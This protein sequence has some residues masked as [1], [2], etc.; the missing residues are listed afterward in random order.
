MILAIT[1][2]TLLF[3]KHVLIPVIGREAF[4]A[5]ALVSKNLHNYLGPAFVLGVVLMLIAWIRHNFPKW[6]DVQWVLKGGGLV[7]SAHPS[8]GR[9]NAGEKGWFWFIA[10]VGLVA[11]ASGIV[12]DF[13]DLV[14]SRANLQLAN[15]I[16]IA[17]TVAWVGGFFGHAYIGT[18]GSE[19]SVEGM[20]TGK[21]DVNWAKQHHDLWY[22]EVARAQAGGDSEPREAPAEA[23]RG[24]A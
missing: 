3:G 16:H 14:G 20:L 9:M 5:F 21:V 19:G 2:L 7:G 24:P 11:C 18:L 8:A 6:V 10:T 13:P 23:Q 22:E 12:L 4:G 1:G 17:S 15:V